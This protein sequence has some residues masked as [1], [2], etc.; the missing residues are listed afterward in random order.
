MRIARSPIAIKHLIESVVTDLSSRANEC[1]VTIQMQATDDIPRV[2]G[3]P[4]KVRRV[5]WHLL[6]NALKFSGEG[7]RVVVGLDVGSLTPQ[8]PHTNGSSDRLVPTGVRVVVRDQGIGIAQETHSR[9]FEPFFQV[10][11]SSTR[12]Y[13]GTGLGL[14]L[15]KSYVEAHGGHIWVESGLGT[16]SSFYVAL[17]AV[18]EELDAYLSQKASQSQQ[19]VDK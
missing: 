10:D 14:T 18:A 2:C 16:G 8:E 17:P 19:K 6:M 5:F 4:E 15:A 13:G 3:D 7:D 9:V 12:K 1:R 11:S